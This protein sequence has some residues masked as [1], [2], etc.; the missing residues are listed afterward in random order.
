MAQSGRAPVEFAGN[1]D[2]AL[3]KVTCPEEAPWRRQPTDDDEHQL[4]IRQSRSAH[5]TIRRART[6]IV[7]GLALACTV[8]GEAAAIPGRY[9]GNIVES[10]QL[11]GATQEEALQ[12]AQA[13]WSSRAGTLGP[14][15]ENWDS[16]GERALECEQEGRGTFKC[17]ATG[18]PC[19]PPG[20]QP[21]DEM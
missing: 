16:A 10:G 15:Y 3:A 19:L 17:T 14:G 6:V 2:G 4:M 21:K 11:T 12:A 1:I 18:R 20:A 13:R 7:Y 8:I 5:R 9:C